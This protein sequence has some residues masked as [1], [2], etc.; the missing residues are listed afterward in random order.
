MIELPRIVLLFGPPASGKLTVGR[1]LA[2]Q[3]RLPLFH[4]HLTVDLLLE[5]FPFG[6]PSFCSLRE[7]IWH[8]VLMETVQSGRSIIF[9]FT[10]EDT[11]S[12]GFVPALQKEVEAAG[13]RI[14]FVELQ[15]TEAEIERRLVTIARTNFKKLQ[16]LDLYREMREKGSFK[17]AGLPPPRAVID[18]SRLSPV[19]AAQQILVQLGLAPG[20]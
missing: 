8:E 7:K 2:T 6:S 10:P 18:T 14:E 3:T 5:L 4:N 13:G 19:E 20:A 15:C 1:E 12:P 11:V 9:T 17:Y 16:S